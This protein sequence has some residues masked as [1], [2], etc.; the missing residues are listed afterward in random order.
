MTTTKTIARRARSTWT[1]ARIGTYFF[2]LSAAAFFLLPLFFSLF[3][4]SLFLFLLFNLVVSIFLL[5]FQSN[6]FFLFE[7]SLLLLEFSAPLVIGGWYR[8]G[9]LHP[10]CFEC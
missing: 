5:L 9:E 6:P 4:F 1:P 8:S 3:L 10:F 2:L 7:N